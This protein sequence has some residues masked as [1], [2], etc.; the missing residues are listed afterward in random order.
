M[1][2][3]TAP[4]DKAPST[5]LQLPWRW[6]GTPVQHY[7]PF[8]WTPDADFRV[9]FGD[10]SGSPG[11]SE[12]LVQSLGDQVPQARVGGH[13]ASQQSCGEEEGLGGAVE[14]EPAGSTGLGESRRKDHSERGWSGLGDGGEE[15]DG[16]QESQS[17]LLWPC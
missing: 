10:K 9:G 12:G 11:T 3:I 2:V 8:T 4:T 6:E 15:Q 14:V 7:V 16:E 5:H 13:G 17:V 1:F